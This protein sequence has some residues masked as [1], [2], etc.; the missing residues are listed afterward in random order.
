MDRV[1]IS[2]GG[3]LAK[4]LSPVDREVADDV[5]RISFHCPSRCPF[6]WLVCPLVKSRLG[7]DL[8][9]AMNLIFRNSI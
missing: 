2:L 5:G 4:V 3:D 6:S 9:L 7:I 1:I 8:I